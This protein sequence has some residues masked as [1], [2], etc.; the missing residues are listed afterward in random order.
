MMLLTL[1]LLIFVDAFDDVVGMDMFVV[2]ASIGDVA[3]IDDVVIVAFV[4]FIHVAD[5]LILHSCAGLHLSTHP[6]IAA[7]NDIFA[8]LLLEEIKIGRCQLRLI[9]AQGWRN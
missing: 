1:F 4:A 8:L 2:T 3:P 9:V 7:F 6:L 5:I